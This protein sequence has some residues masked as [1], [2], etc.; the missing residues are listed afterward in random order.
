MATYTRTYGD[1]NDFIAPSDGYSIYNIDGGAGS[2]T[3][4]ADA[5]STGFSISPINASGITTISGASGTK[6]NLNNVEKISFKDGRSFTLETVASTP[7]ATQPLA[8][9]GTANNDILQATSANNSI[10]GGAGIDTL[11]L[12]NISASSV[13][14]G[15][16]GNN[17][18]LNGT[19]TGSDTLINVE[20]IH[21]SD[22]K[23][24][25]DISASGSAGETIQFIGTVA[26]NLKTSTPIVGAVLAVADQT[27]LKGIFQ[28]AINLGLIRDLSGDGS[29]LDIAKMAYL[30]IFG[31]AAD[32]QTANDLASYMN[33]GMSQ[34][35]FLMAAASLVDLTGIQ[36]TGVEYI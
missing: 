10:D 23:I 29:N 20:R 18:T 28:T 36:T 6:I 13:T 17:W 31:T 24:A 1:G 19:G 5:R 4:F 30:N 14:F 25:L 9:T 12:T 27:D 35:D 15:K 33:N 16:S 22:K 26:S 21:F 11:L 32:N 3:F 7:I 8:I 34:I 2:D